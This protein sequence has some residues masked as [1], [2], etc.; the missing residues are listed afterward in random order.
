MGSRFSWYEIIEAIGIKYLL[1]AID[2][3]SKCDWV[4]SFKDQTG[5]IVVNAFWSIWNSSIRK[6]NELWV[7]QGGEFYNILTKYF[8]E[9]ITLKCT[10]PLIKKIQL[11]LKDLSEIWK[12]RLLS[13]WQLFQRLFIFMF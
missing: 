10:Q 3:R 9:K 5:I 2:L 7:D 12:T 4:V 11:L 13:I 8:W 1:C 6:P